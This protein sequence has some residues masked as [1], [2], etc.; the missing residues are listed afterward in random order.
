MMR[1]AW[2]RAGDPCVLHR[3]SSLLPLAVF[4]QICD[5]GL[6]RVDEPGNQDRTQMSSYIATRWY[7]SPEVRKQTLQHGVA[8]C[9]S[10]EPCLSRAC[11]LLCPSGHSLVSAVYESSR[12]V[13]GWYVTATDDRR[14]EMRSWE[15]PPRCGATCSFAVALSPFCV[16]SGCILAELIG[17]KPIFPGRDSFHQITLIVGILGT[18]P[19]AP[20][21][22]A[23]SSSSA[24][25]RNKPNPPPSTG[26]SADYV[27]ALPRKA[28]IPFNQLY[29]KASALACDL[30]DKLLCF[31]PDDRLTVEQ[32]LRHPY[33]ADLHCDDD[34]PVCSSM[35]YSD[36]YW[37]YLRVTRDDL[38]TLIHQEIVNHYKEEIFE[39]PPTLL[40]ADPLNSF[41]NSLRKNLPAANA[42]AP[43][44]ATKKGRRK[45]F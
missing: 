8:Q 13:V 26:P 1:R 25:S 45:S 34:E 9:E 32:A 19:P 24:S 27:S 39:E 6:A 17:R 7:R 11:L 43:A 44:A 16:F 35:D 40:T 37:E 42:H 18:P 4:A 10:A 29:P 38:R 23:S 28:K 5:F 2:L 33:L 3:S 20:V 22:P 31:D 36:F 15:R 21:A 30:L 41:Q 14:G 12:H